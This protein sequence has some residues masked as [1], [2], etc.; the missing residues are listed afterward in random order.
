MNEFRE[1]VASI[2][3]YKLE[4]FVTINIFESM[5]NF[6]EKDDWQFKEVKAG[7]ILQLEVSLENANYTCYAIADDENRSFR[8]YSDCPVK[9][10]ENKRLAVAEFLTRANYG[11]ITG[12]FELNFID[13]DIRY[14]TSIHVA[15]QRL[16]YSLIK[17]LVYVNVTTMDDYF[18]GLMKVIYG[19][20]SAEQALA[21]IENQDS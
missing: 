9:V 21:E 17:R 19:G 5:T 4:E 8:F 14:K 7:E 20:T 18:P 1:E 15:D 13:G 6:F 11:L 3:C 12:N 10:P 16:S 2:T